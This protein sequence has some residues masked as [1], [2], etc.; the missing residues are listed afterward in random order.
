VLANQF[1][2]IQVSLERKSG[3][4]ESFEYV[5]HADYVVDH[6]HFDFDRILER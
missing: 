6:F 1:R 2:P 5:L 4:H 3:H